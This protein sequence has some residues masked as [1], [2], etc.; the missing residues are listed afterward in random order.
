MNA[1]NFIF[2]LVHIPNFPTL[3]VLTPPRSPYTPSVNYAHLSTD[4][5]NFFT[6]Y[7]NKFNDYMN[8]PNH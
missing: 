4:Y 6:N 7:A 3:V 2:Q 1:S 5:I 8:T